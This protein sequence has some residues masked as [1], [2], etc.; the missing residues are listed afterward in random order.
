MQDERKRPS[1]AMFRKQKKLRL[2]EREKMAGSLKHFLQNNQDSTEGTETIDAT[3]SQDSESVISVTVSGPSEISTEATTVTSGPATSGGGCSSKTASTDA[4]PDEAMTPSSSTALEQSTSGNSACVRSSVMTVMSATE[5]PA[6]SDTFDEG[7]NEA[8]VDIIPSDPGLWPERITN[9]IA[10]ILVKRGPPLIDISFSFP[11]NKDKRK[12]SCKYF[13]RS[14]ANGEKVE[15]TWLI[16]SISKDSVFCFCCKLFCKT[17]NTFCDT[18]GLSDWQHLSLLIK[19]HETSILHNSYMNTWVNLK[20]MLETSTT[21][22]AHHLRILETEKKYWRDVLERII[23][24]VKYLSTQCLAFQGSS[25]LLFEQDNGNFLKAVEMIASF[26]SVMRQHVSR[27]CNSQ[28][29]SVKMTHYLGMQIQNEIIELLSS[30]VRNN[31]LE[32]VRSSKYFSI[33]LDCTPDTSHTKQISLVLRYVVLNTTSKKVEVKES[34]IAFNPI[35]DSTGE[36]IYTFL[37]EILKKLN[38]DI[39]NIR[40]QGYDNGANM[41]GNHVGL[42]K[43]ILDANPRAL[44]VP[45]AAHTL[46]LTVNDASKVSDATIQFFNLVQ[47]LYNF[48]SSSTKRWDVMRKNVPGLSLKPLSET[49]WSSRIDS[50]KPLKL[51]LIK[52]CESLLEV[53]EDNSFHIDARHKASSLLTSVQNFQF[54]CGIIIWHDVLFHINIVSK[55]MQSATINIKVCQT[56]LKNLVDH[57]QQYRS[58]QSFQEILVQAKEV[59]LSL[60]IEDD[61]PPLPTVRRKF[62][63]KLFDY[64]HRDETPHDPKTAFK[65]SFFLKIIDQTLSSLKNRFDLLNEY[66]NIFVFF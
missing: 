18:N 7:F 8:S 34:F 60:E 54:I 30:K 63:P 40:G 52:V 35:L 10:R 57:F 55:Q 44:F 24:I 13:V 47:E 58:D 1:G 20:K 48:F 31:I 4:E 65:I 50:I 39:K 19:R 36:G 23:A 61:F 53:A 29:K 45:C 28:K 26:D 14:L 37:T 62:K 51:Y 38:L 42:Q 15:S 56:Y 43:R 33:I 59:A 22:N 64:E 41:K 17:P 2:Q 16:Y 46:N 25:K 9:E 21:V 11:S 32:M 27:V 49:R 5:I 66:D 6:A 12:F 3:E